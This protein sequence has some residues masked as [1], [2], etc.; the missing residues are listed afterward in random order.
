MPSRVRHRTRSFPATGALLAAI[1]SLALLVPGAAGAAT[2]VNGGFESGDLTGWQQQSPYP[3]SSS[4]YAYSGTE[5]P[6]SP[7]FPPVPAPPAGS[8][9]AIVDQGPP[10][11]IVLYQD[12]VVEPGNTQQLSMLLY[13]N[14]DEE[15]KM[16]DPPTLSLGVINQQYRVDL[17]RPSAP[18]DSVA[19]GDVLAPIFGTK[20]GDPQVRTPFPQTVELA[21][22]AGQTVRLRF[23]QSATNRLR[24]GVDSVAILGEPPQPPGPSPAPAGPSAPAAAPPAPAASPPSNAIVVGKFVPNLKKGTAKLKV[25]VPGPGVLLAADARAKGKMLRKASVTTTAAGTL[26]VPLVASSAGLR[27]LRERSKLRVSVALAFTPTGGTAGQ[28]FV[29]RALKLKPTG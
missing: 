28:V 25:S 14:S 18:L 27:I 19:P 5:S 3:D 10:S 17:M 22:F 20:T 13:Y 12:I 16:P 26:T 15:M 2:V 9:A 24:A 29:Q 11:Q 23:A 7:A 6:R 4:W 8:F 1:A 21:P